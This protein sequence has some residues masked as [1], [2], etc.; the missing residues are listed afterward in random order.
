MKRIQIA[1]GYGLRIM[2][3]RSPISFDEDRRTARRG[4]LHSWTEYGVRSPTVSTARLAVPE[5]ASPSIKRD[6]VTTR[7]GN[8]Y[9]PKN[10][11]ARRSRCTQITPLRG[12]C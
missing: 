5:K 11:F 9:N 12:C 6:V 10:I 4:S 3:G 1:V 8:F 2:T 7:I